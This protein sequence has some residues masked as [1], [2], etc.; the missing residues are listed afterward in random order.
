MK[1]DIEKLLEKYYDGDTTL[2]EEKQLRQ[3]FQQETIP[4]H[5]LSHADQFRYFADARNEH[6]SA[7]FNARLA[8]KLSASEPG[9][10]RSLTSW[11]MRIA[12]SVTLLFLGFG[13]GRLYDQ[14]RQSSHQLAANAQDEAPMQAMKKVL[15]FSEMPKTSASER[16][17]AV[18]Q[19]YELNKV[20]NDITQLLVNTLNFDANVNVRL[21]ACEALARFE[22]EPGVREALI[23]SLK[24][25]TDPNVQLTLI[26][27]LVAIKEKRAA[28]EMKRLA[29]NQETLDIVRT[30]AQEGLNQLIGEH[31]S[32]S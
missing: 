24:I 2:A 5:L 9:R 20:D 12:A 25:Q 18:Q 16:I 7:G 32:P 10:V 30:K 31:R 13:A 17:Q 15:S 6:P 1:Q 19:S 29:H 11:I 14:W 22:N 27:V 4:E 3:F 8:E 23:Q 28:D 26:D 21:A